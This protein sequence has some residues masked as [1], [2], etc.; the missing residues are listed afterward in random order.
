MCKGREENTS[1]APHRKGEEMITYTDKENYAVFNQRLA[2]HLMNLGFV[3][4]QSR[5]DKKGTGRNV[6]IFRNSPE[7]IKAI[8]GYL[9]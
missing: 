8:T 3:L 7:L 9:K 2:G 6:F 5:P 4:L 1:P